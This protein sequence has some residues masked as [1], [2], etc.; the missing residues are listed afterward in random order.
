[1]ITFN[2]I[3]FALIGGTIPAVVWLLFWL[4]EDANHPES[5]FLITKTFL[6]GMSMVVLVLPFQNLVNTLFPGMTLTA[7]IL[8]AVLE[9]SFKFAAA[10]FIA[11]RWRNCDEPV[12]NM[13]FMIAAALGFV[14]L[15]NALFIF[16]PLL[17]QDITGA[18]SSGAFRFIG[19]SLLHIVSSA[20][21]GTALAL[22]FYKKTKNRIFWVSIAF[23]VA[24]VIHTS[25]NMFILQEKTSVTFLTFCMV[26]ACVTL[27]LLFFERVKAL[28]PSKTDI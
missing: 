25:F 18:V 19:A 11:I 27:L 26:W 8:W 14:A 16:N 10:Y 6:A 3:F 22:T 13:I 23:I 12:D 28:Q 1:M 20:T 5:P 4:K 2:T 17:Q 21:I 24:V 15:E 7:F 9:E